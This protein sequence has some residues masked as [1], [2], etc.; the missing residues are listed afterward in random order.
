[1]DWFYVIL[2][3]T[4]ASVLTCWLYYLDLKKT[5]DIGYTYLVWRK[6]IVIKYQL[7]YFLVGLLFFILYKT[8]FSV[9]SSEKNPMSIAKNSSSEKTP[10]FM[11][12]LAEAFVLSWL[13]R[14]VCSSKALPFF[15]GSIYKFIET[16]FFKTIKEDIIEDNRA[17]KNIYAQ[18]IIDSYNKSAS[19]D[20]NLKIFGNKLITYG[21]ANKLKL[22]EITSLVK[23]INQ[24]NSLKTAI[25]ITLGIY[26]KK[27]LDNILNS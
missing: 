5:Y 20:L 26:S 14:G 10:E 3:G 6:S 1:V 16:N 15:N 22:A 25:F 7:L 19:E 23:D 17:G 24:A 2:G 13:T 9:F 8:G 18:N 4:V 12:V 11:L 21:Q 27:Q